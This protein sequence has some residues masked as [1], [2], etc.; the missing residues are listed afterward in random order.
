MSPADKAGIKKGDAILE[1][2]GFLTSNLKRLNTTEVEEKIRG[3]P[4]TKVKIKIFR[5]NIGTIEEIELERIYQHAYD[6]YEEN[7]L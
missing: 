4:R 2:D 3:V 7:A 5:N 6:L 1:V